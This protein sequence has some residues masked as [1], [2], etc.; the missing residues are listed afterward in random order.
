MAV[1]LAK[2]LMHLFFFSLILTDDEREMMKLELFSFCFRI[3]FCIFF[4]F[5][6]ISN[7]LNHF[8]RREWPTTE[9]DQR[10]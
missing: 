5:F 8:S 7:I 1:V 3:Y 10:K 9:G 2:Q 4:L 6:M